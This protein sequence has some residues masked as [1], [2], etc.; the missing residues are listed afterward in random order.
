MLFPGMMINYDIKFCG[1]EKGV[2]AEVVFSFVIFTLHDIVTI[3]IKNNFPK[4]FGTI[5]FGTVLDIKG[6]V[7]RHLPFEV[8]LSFS[9]D[10]RQW[11]IDFGFVSDNDNGIVLAVADKTP[12]I[13]RLH[14]I[15]VG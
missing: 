2:E 13:L 6:I 7:E 12:D 15:H 1:I 10:G 4:Q 9:A 5:K 8:V 3:F 11:F 14:P